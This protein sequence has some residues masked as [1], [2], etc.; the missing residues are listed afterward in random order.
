MFSGRVKQ[1][2]LGL[3]MAGLTVVPAT[4]GATSLGIVNGDF[5]SGLTGWSMSPDN[6]FAATMNSYTHSPVITSY[7]AD[8]RGLGIALSNSF[9]IYQ[10]IDLS[11]YS[12]NIGTGLATLSLHG[13]GYGETGKDK[14]IMHMSFLDVGHG[15][16]GGLLD[17]NEATESGVWTSLSIGSTV[18]PTSTYYVLI[19]LEAM[20]S[21]AVGE[22]YANVG[23]DNIYG[24]LYLPEPQP[25]QDPYQDPNV[26]PEPGTILL[27]GT[28]I[29]GLAAWRR[30]K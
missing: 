26:V 12:A 20:K 24:T 1:F 11:S 7:F 8:A 23:F 27:L 9:S 5:E 15:V 18:I 10:V 17:S 22:M 14:G 13:M 2:V 25:N 30:R 29:V 6:T 4:A 28:G 21:S 16:L 3:M 19:E